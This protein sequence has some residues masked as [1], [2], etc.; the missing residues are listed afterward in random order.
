M[1]GPV[2][3]EYALVSPHL[4]AE[5]WTKTETSYGELLASCAKNRGV[6]PG[7]RGGG[8]EIRTPEGLPPT[9][10]P[11]MLASVHQ[12]SPPSVT[13]QNATGAAAGERCRTGVNET[14]TETKDWAAFYGAARLRGDAP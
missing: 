3:V 6:V 14:E 4:K 8:W 1:M 2:A 11:T 7:Q 5:V 10:F 13:C 9:R 12:C